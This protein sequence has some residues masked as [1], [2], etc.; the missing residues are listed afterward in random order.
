MRSFFA[1]L[2]KSIK[3]LKKVILLV[4]SVRS[5]MKFAFHYTRLL[6]NKNPMLDFLN[7]HDLSGVIMKTVVVMINYKGKIIRQSIFVPILILIFAWSSGVMAGIGSDETGEAKKNRKEEATKS[8]PLKKREFE[9]RDIKGNNTVIVM[10]FDEQ[11][12][13]KYSR[14][15]AVADSIKISRWAQTRKLEPIPDRGPIIDRKASFV[16]KFGSTVEVENLNPNKDYILY[17][18][19]VSYRKGNGGINSR[20][21]IKADGVNIADIPFGGQNTGKLF[22]ISIPRNL[23][24]DGKLIFLFEESATTSGVWGIW[25]MMISAGELPPEIA[26]KKKI[27][28]LL[29]KEQ[30]QL[31]TKKSGSEKRK[32]GAGKENKKSEGTGEKPV[33]KEKPEEKKIVEPKVKEIN[34]LKNPDQPGIKEVIDPVINSGEINEPEVQEPDI[35]DR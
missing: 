8:E 3:Q 9:N 27:P 19:F 26:V 4:F 29:N 31:E 32:H 30:D 13:V 15:D 7:D 2:G 35:R 16:S 18:D 5:I 12:N 21:S 6:D 33:P 17:I 34:D 10:N 1:F 28:D 24:Y 11:D 20:L 22:A 23:V 25:D 14:W